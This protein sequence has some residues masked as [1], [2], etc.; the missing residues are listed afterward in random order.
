[1]A[2]NF[3]F[4]A[5]KWQ[6]L[7]KECQEAELLVNSSPKACAILCRSALEKGVQWLYQN[8]ATLEYPY[9]KKLASLIHEQ[10]F[11]ELVKPIMFKEINI[12]RL[13]GNNGAHG[14]TVTSFGAMATLKYLFRFMSFIAVYYSETD[15]VIPPF[16]EQLLPNKN[17]E[18]ESL[19]KLQDLDSKLAQE[20]E[21]AIIDRKQL[22]E[23][24][25]TIES[26]RTALTQKQEAGTKNRKAKEKEVIPARAIPVLIPEKVTRKLYIDVSLCEVGWDN[27]QEGKELEYEVKGMPISTNPSGIGYVDYVL[28]GKDGNPLAVVEAKKTMADARVGRHQAVLYADCLEKMHGQRPI[29]FYTNGFE[30]YLWDDCF[31]TERDVQGFYT[32]DELQLLLDRRKT[33]MDPRTY[34]VNQNIAGRPYQIE[35]IK[36]V[37]EAIAVSNSKGELRGAKRA[38]LLVM[39]TGS[40]KTR[41]AAAL[42]DILSKCN[43]VKRVLFLADRNALVTQAKNAFKEYL[44]ELSAI[45]LTKEKEDNGT[46]L[47]FSTYPTIMNKIDSAGTDNERFYGV[48]HFDLIITDEAHRSIYS[49]YK[50]IFDYFDTLVVGLTAT[51]KKDI[52]RNTYSLFGIED[53]V[54]TFAY[55]LNTA[56]NEGFLVPPK[57]ISVPLKFVRDGI[58]YDELSERE[59]EEYEDKFGDPT[60]QE[61]PDSISNSALNKWLFNADTV[62]KVLDHLMNNG[63]KVNGGDKLA[64]TIIFAKNHEH[65]MFIEERFNKNYPEY[66]GHF[67]R[68]IDNYETKA[69]DL[70]EKFT[71]K[72]EELDPQIAVSVDMMDTGIDAPRV[73]N[74]VFFKLVRS[75]S[76]FWQMIGRG[77]RLCPDLFGP[78]ADKKEFLIFDYCQNFEFFE[79]NPEGYINKN[80]KPLLQHI[81]ETKLQVAQLIADQTEKT[82]DDLEIRTAYLQELYRVVVGLDKKRFE[83]KK[84]LRYV[85]EYCHK[86]KWS[87]LSKSD[88]LDIK[89]HLSHLQP[90]DK[91][92][93]LARRFDMLV[94]IYQALFLTEGGKIGNYQ[95][96][97][98]STAH[99]L[100][101][102]DNIPQ[103]KQQITL[104]KDIQTEAYWKTISIKKL[105]TLRVALRD[106]IKYLEKNSI[107]PVYTFF[108]DDLD[109]DNIIVTDVLGSYTNLQ[110]YRDRVESYVRKN[111]NHFTILKL[112]N[113]QPINPKEIDALE[114][115][116]FTES[117][118][119]TK[120]Q[121][122]KEYGELPLGVFIR[123]V[124]GLDKEAVSTAF[125]DFLLTGNLK[126]DQMTF[127]QTI[128]QYLTKNGVL[129]KTM[130]FEPPFTD[131][132]DQGIV[133]IFDNE[134]H[135]RKVVGIIDSING[136]G[137]VA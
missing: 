83:V 47:V 93:E 87:N 124:V 17:I 52:D 3:D 60:N 89:T 15:V 107:T 77:T 53:D 114:E 112:H 97:I 43:W 63:I 59:K 71:N 14:K 103:V 28:W 36:R 119:G 125:S 44:P 38:C 55:E 41:T 21:Q 79:E 37:S 136:N 81:F 117:A 126:A 133:G 105:E 30:T 135:I 132:N 94:L 51:P 42:V 100:Q 70:L 90:A 49:K 11:Q 102:K 118:A 106:L 5:L 62:D 61:A 7:F 64:K 127:I 26:L 10:A 35:A 27:L 67:L 86:D 91:D 54:P 16:D 98:I 20:N 57:S 29:I 2:S 13:S 104:I 6:P 84:E 12:I 131:M 48:G 65:A 18:R 31:Y 4:L 123:S 122:V 32:Q 113:N 58:K 22:E 75:S 115:M 76:K 25:K 80:A 46:R 110:T 66:G 9:D 33:R 34:S 96:R 92:D 78:G 23:Q 69:Q 116:F 130:L 68:V 45:D 74:L 1:M 109:T 134:S 82:E 56:V 101:K 19:K 85:T 108:E 120:E 24:A 137:E 40:G 111:K 50:A 73:A 88:V 39:A 95:G 128:M 8:E 121:Y 129:N 99:A 72:Y